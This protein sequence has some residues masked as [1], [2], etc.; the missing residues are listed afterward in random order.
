MK[1]APVLQPFSKIKGGARSYEKRWGNA[2]CKRQ[3][4]AL[5][6]LGVGKNFTVKACEEFNADC[7]NCK[8]YILEG[9]LEWY[10]D[11]LE[12]T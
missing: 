8:L 7:G 4:K 2:V 10:R 12:W 6:M 9:M 11:V 5:K 3:L 1:K